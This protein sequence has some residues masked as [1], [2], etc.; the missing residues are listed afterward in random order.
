MPIV[1]IREKNCKNCSVRLDNDADG[2]LTN[3][4]KSAEIAKVFLFLKFLQS[5]R[6][7]LHCQVTNARDE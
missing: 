7:R 3:L 2:A 1:S 5:E 6:A 4:H